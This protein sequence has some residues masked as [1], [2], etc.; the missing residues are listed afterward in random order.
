M[1]KEESAY[2]LI[3]NKNS[4]IPLILTPD[5]IQPNSVRIINSSCATPL[6]AIIKKPLS[7][8]EK[9]NELKQIIA[10]NRNSLFEADK[11]GNTPLIV[12]ELDNQLKVIKFLLQRESELFSSL[13]LLKQEN[14]N[15]ENALMAAVCHGHLDSADYLLEK[16]PS[17]LKR[18]N[19]HNQSVFQ[20]SF[21]ANNANEMLNYLYQHLRHHK[22]DKGY[23]SLFPDY[24]NALQKIHLNRLNIKRL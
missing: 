4:A 7:I 3:I 22:R 14:N 18:R 10:D 21:H 11:D 12:A 13:R 20:I 23:T 17:L 5:F 15:G 2:F 1:L 6:I 16:A 9:I 24:Q 19:Y 8:R